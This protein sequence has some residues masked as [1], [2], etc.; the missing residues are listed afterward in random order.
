MTEEKDKEAIDTSISNLYN[1]F[2][3]MREVQY[4]IREMYPSVAMEIRLIMDRVRDE[5]KVL[6]GLVA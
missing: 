1:H 3:D 2:A 6:M 5:F 4:Q